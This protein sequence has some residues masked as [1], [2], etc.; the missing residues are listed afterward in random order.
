MEPEG[1]LPRTIGAPATRA[2]AAIGVTTLDQLTQVREVDL[3]KLHG[4]GPKALGL[5]RDALGAQGLAFAAEI[6]G[7]AAP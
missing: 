5:L 4:M 3:R 2:L 7:P 6:D 1:D